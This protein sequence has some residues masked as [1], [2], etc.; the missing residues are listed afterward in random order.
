M[1]RSHIIRKVVGGQAP[2]EL[3]CKRIASIVTTL[4]GSIVCQSLNLHDEQPAF[5]S[6][7]SGLDGYHVQLTGPEFAT[8]HMR[9]HRKAK[10]APRLLWPTYGI[11]RWGRLLLIL[12][13]LVVLSVQ[14]CH[15]ALHPLEIIVPGGNEHQACPL[16]HAVAA[17]FTVLSLLICAAFLLGHV[18][19]P[20]PWQIRTCFI[21]CLA[22][23]PP[24]M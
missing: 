15:P 12:L 20:R 5:P 7:S 13:S 17:L 21:H 3:T 16:S 18:Q 9:S 10:G 1:E 14:V 23:R 11:G 2:R 8:R 19:E 6:S 4:V 22:P 24:P